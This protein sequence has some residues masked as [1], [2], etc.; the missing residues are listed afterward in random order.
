M[1]AK[2][3]SMSVMV[4]G[5]A[6]VSASPPYRVCDPSDP[7]GGRLKVSAAERERLGVRKK[8]WPGVVNPEVYTKLDALTKRI[9]ELKAVL[10]EKEGRD[11]YAWGAMFST[12]FEGTVYVQVLLRPD[13]DISDLERQVLRALKGSEFYTVYLFRTAPAF[14]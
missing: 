2:L 3:L 8:N 9:A 6:T 1:I 7:D 14:V 5:Q 11:E 13:K 12:Q 10:H 4:L